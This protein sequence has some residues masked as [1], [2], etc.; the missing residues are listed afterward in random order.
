MTDL[1]RMSYSFWIVEKLFDHC[2]RICGMIKQRGKHSLQPTHN[3]QY[4]P[5]GHIEL[6]KY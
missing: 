6:L 4:D 5:N 1:I 2:T 3:I